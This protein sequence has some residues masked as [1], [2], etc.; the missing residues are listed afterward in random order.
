MCGL[1]A[2]TV[3][4][5]ESD[6]SISS[7]QRE[8]DGFWDEKSASHSFKFDDSATRTVQVHNG[9]ACALFFDDLVPY[10][11]E[12]NA[13]MQEDKGL[14]IQ[15]LA[16][17]YS[18]PKLM[19]ELIEEKPSQVLATW[20]E[21]LSFLTFGTNRPRTAFWWSHLHTFSP[22]RKRSWTI[23]T[24]Q[25]MFFS[26]NKSREKR[27]CL[28]CRYFGCLLSLDTG[29]GGVQQPLLSSSRCRSTCLP[30][31]TSTVSQHPGCLLPEQLDQYPF[32]KWDWWR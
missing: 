12:H 27:F 25:T 2:G 20:P 26:Q 18:R 29:I 8:D 11:A 30:F 17:S 7:F 4:A 22:I 21:Y 10:S 16:H 3:D 1:R 32:A 15:E 28:R 5:G 31:H 6:R 14:R 13:A 19:R 9:S 23:F 24:W